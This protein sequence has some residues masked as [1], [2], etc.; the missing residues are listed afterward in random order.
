M[1][2]TGRILTTVILYLTLFSIIR[3]PAR[4]ATESSNT[5][6]SDDEIKRSITEYGLSDEEINNAI[7]KSSYTPESLLEAVEK[8][9]EEDNTQKNRGKE[10]ELFKSA[11]SDDSQSGYKKYGKRLANKAENCWHYIAKYQMGLVHIMRNDNN[12]LI[13]TDEYYLDYISELNA[14]LGCK[15]SSDILRALYLG[16]NG[17]VLYTK[18]RDKE[19]YLSEERDDALDLFH[20]VT[21]LSDV[22]FFLAKQVE[23]DTK[24]YDFITGG[25]Y[26]YRMTDSIGYRDR[27]LCF[28]LEY[29]KREKYDKAFIMDISYECGYTNV[30]ETIVESSFY[31]K[32]PKYKNE[33]EALKARVDEYALR[34]TGSIGECRFDY[35]LEDEESWD[36][37]ISNR[38]EGFIA[39]DYALSFANLEIPS[40]GEEKRGLSAIGKWDDEFVQKMEEIIDEEGYPT[41]CKLI[42]SGGYVI[43][44]SE[45]NILALDDLLK[46]IQKAYSHAIQLNEMKDGN[47]VPEIL[48][49]KGNEIEYLWGSQG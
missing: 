20:E 1:K 41:E 9:M 47:H 13:L 27:D 12:Q 37:K 28:E 44:L 11:L 49:N 36:V 6:I 16:A 10:L 29:G 17:E 8:I 19:R 7:T 24:W 35:N 46:K 21:M 45:D 25:H 26:K 30:V 34:L 48:A 4:A 15:D 3:I 5:Q 40:K 22:Y 2:K 43:K 32:R 33:E 23:A 18:D 31:E 39:P 14:V 42:I 38:H